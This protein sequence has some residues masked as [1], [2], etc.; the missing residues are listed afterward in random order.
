MKVE[1]RNIKE[2]EKESNVLKELKVNLK[3][4][5]KDKD[6][7]LTHKISDSKRSRK[8]NETL[9]HMLI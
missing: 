1:R 3:A 7:Q 6:E 9:N 8:E 2:S 5:V 4:S